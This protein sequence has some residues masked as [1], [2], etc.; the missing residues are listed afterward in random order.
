[1]LMLEISIWKWI[2]GS[3]RGAKNNNIV[4]QQQQLRLP[5]CATMISLL[6]KGRINQTRAQRRYAFCLRGTYIS[7]FSSQVAV[8]K[9]DDKLVSKLNNLRPAT[10]QTELRRRR[11]VLFL[12]PASQSACLFVGS[13]RN[14]KKM[15]LKGTSHIVCIVCCNGRTGVQT[16]QPRVPHSS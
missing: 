14:N 3:T 6:A 11:N 8:Y 4:M 9:G 15:Y 2:H 5:I 10:H 12:V 7:P 13:R 16:Q 1:M